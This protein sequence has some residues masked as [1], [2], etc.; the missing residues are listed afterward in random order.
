MFEGIPNT[1][2]TGVNSFDE[3]YDLLKKETLKDLERSPE[4]RE[5]LE[6]EKTLRDRVVEEN[7]LSELIERYQL[8]LPEFKEIAEGA[9]E[10]DISK[11]EETELAPKLPEGYGYKGGGARYLLERILG[12]KNIP[13]P[14][15]LDIVR[16]ESVTPSDELDQELSEKYM[17]DDLKHGHGVEVIHD[18]ETYLD[19]H[20][21]TI[22]ELYATST[23]I[24]CSKKCLI[25]T[26]RGILRVSTNQ[27]E[28]YSSTPHGILAK[29]TRLYTQAIIDYNKDI[30]VHEERH[31]ERSFIPPFWLALNLNKAWERGNDHAELYCMELKRTK[32]VPERLQTVQE[33]ADYLLENIEGE[34]YYRNAP[35]EYYETEDDW[36]DEYQDSMTKKVSGRK[37]R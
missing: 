24:I 15:D 34:F 29:I 12:Y 7:D 18:N 19:S 25:D 28:H 1:K 13:E 31:I 21:L 20:D 30:E 3:L 37:E 16:L 9:Y 32:R 23:S 26:I 5:G 6:V 8:H 10:I 4:K 33:I 27:Y 11:L 36:A 22:N 2:D 35:K 14:R 17:P